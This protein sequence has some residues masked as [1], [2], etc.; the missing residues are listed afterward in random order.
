[1][2]IS[3]Q[4]DGF[5]RNRWTVSSEYAH[6][7]RVRHSISR[8][9][10]YLGEKGLFDPLPCGEIFAPLLDAYLEWLQHYQHAAAGTLELRA[11]Y[12]TAFLHWLGPEATPQGVAT[13]SPESVEAFFLAYAQ[14]VG[15]AARRSMQSTLRTFLRFCL[16]QGFVRVSLDLAVPTLRTYKLASVPRGLTEAQAR[17]VL[18]GIDRRTAVGRRDYAIAELLFTYGARGGQVRAMRLEQIDWARNRILF[19]AS[20][21]GKESCLPLTAEVGESLLD[22][23]QNARPPS[24][25][26]QVFLTSR[27]PYHPLPHSNALSAIIE[28]RIR[29]AGIAIPS[30]G[31]HAF[32]HGFATRMLAQGEPLKAIADVLGHRHLG[33]TFIYTKV[34]FNALQQ[35]A[36]E[37]PQEVAQ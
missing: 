14:K 37:W 7:K 31:A 36:L 32:R 34:D 23:L 18:Q 25:A 28:R 9:V 2:H 19:A 29:A 24:S 10:E 17:Q 21:G 8:F 30:K 22:Y 20:K 27:A 13:L 33:T 35:V 15:K 16:H 11:Q 5:L 6:L 26:P 3:E 4:V 12:L 1:L